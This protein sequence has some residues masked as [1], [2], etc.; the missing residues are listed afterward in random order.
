M[1]TCLCC[2]PKCAYFYAPSS[3]IASPVELVII[4]LSYSAATSSSEQHTEM[5]NAKPER[6]LTKIHKVVEAALT[7]VHDAQCDNY[8]PGKTK[9]DTNRD[10]IE[11]SDLLMEAK[12]EIAAYVYLQH[13]SP[14][15]RILSDPPCQSVHRQH[16]WPSC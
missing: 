10:L 4:P 7:K 5:E 3:L 12:E 9:E 8:D 14:T 1:Q 15:F 2:F 13:P 16:S 11:A 6:D